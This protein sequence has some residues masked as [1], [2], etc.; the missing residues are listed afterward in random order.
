MKKAVIVYQSQTGTTKKYGEEISSFL[1]ENGIETI[2]TSVKDFKAESII[3]ADYLFLGCWTSGLFILLQHPEKEWVTF[4]KSLP[5]LNGTK[6][7][8]FT[9]YK[10]ATGSMFRN[11]KKCVDDKTSNLVGE[12]KSKNGLLSELDKKVITGLIGK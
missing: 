2:I 8:F 3:N 10:L 6:V 9:T 12:L 11:M 1:L 7:I 5:K 4:A